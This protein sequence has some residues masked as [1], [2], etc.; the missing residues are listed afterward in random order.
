[1]LAGSSSACA[2]PSVGLQPGQA[3]LRS[4]VL[5]MSPARRLESSLNGGPSGYKHGLMRTPGME[6]NLASGAGRAAARASPQDPCHA[7]SC[8]TG[9]VVF[10]FC[11]IFNIIFLIPKVKSVVE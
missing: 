6:P 7:S 8:M 10:V 9:L 2:W 11:L 5:P 1:M 3:S 4:L